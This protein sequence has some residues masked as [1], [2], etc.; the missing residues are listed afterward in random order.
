MV[1]FQSSYV[2]IDGLIFSITNNVSQVM[3]D[4]KER[5]FGKS[6]YTI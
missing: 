2:Y 4:H 3:V 6:N 5:E 1:K